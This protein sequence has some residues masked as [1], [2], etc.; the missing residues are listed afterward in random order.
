MGHRG[1][2]P[3]SGDGRGAGRGGGADRLGGRDSCGEGHR[4]RADEGV[5]SAHAVDRRDVE[6]GYGQRSGGRGP[7]RGRYGGAVGTGGDYGVGGAG[8]NQV[9]GGLDGGGQALDRPAE[10]GRRLGLVHHQPGQARRAR[11][12]LGRLGG[13][14]G[15]VEDADREVSRIGP[16][17]RPV[18]REDRD[19]GAGHYGLRGEGQGAGHVFGADLVVGAGGDR[20][21]VLAG[22]VH[23]DH[24]QSRRHVGHH[25]HAVGVDSLGG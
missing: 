17:E 9:G 10:D 20:D 11:Q 21:D 18:D 12:Y 2:C 15:Q 13:D 24:G 7:R 6:A 14:R 23:R 22:L 4:E 16:G 3:G 5:A 19:L 1:L 8:G 25:A